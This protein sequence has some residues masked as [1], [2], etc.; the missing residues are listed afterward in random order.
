M[1]KLSSQLLSFFLDD[2]HANDNIKV[3]VLYIY[4][5]CN[6][7]IYIYIITGKYVLF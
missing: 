5:T 7:Y 1:N 2:N 6:V 3:V 4:I